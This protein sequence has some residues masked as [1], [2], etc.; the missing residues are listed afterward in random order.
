[1]I[2]MAADGGAFNVAMHAFLDGRDTPPRFDRPPT[3]R[4]LPIKGTGWFVIVEGLIRVTIFIAYLSLISLLPD[5]R[6]VFEYH[7]AEHK[8]ISCYEAGLELTPENAQQFSRFHPRCGQALSVEGGD[9]LD[10]RAVSFSEGRV[11]A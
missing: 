8:T 2:G 3:E 9:E 11:T 7:G 1:M 6:R 10:V 4:L 5:L